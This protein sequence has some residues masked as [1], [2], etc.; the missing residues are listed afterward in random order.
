V[1]ITKEIKFEAGHRLAKGYPGNCRHVHGHSYLATV[2]M[3]LTARTLNK[4]G[5]VKDFGD[6]KE[7]KKWVDDNWD[8]AFLVAD[9]DFSMRDFLKEDGQQHF[10]FEGNPTAENIAKVLFGKASE[11]LNDSCSKVTKIIVKETATSEAIYTS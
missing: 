2:E 1:K 8:H 11:I 10:V 3:A 9:D 6:F 4:Y 7:L 5:F